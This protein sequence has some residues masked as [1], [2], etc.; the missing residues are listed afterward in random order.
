MIGVRTDFRDG[1]VHGL[2]IM[3][4]GICT[5]IV[6]LPSTSSSIGDIA[7]QVVRAVAGRPLT[8]LA[9]RGRMHLDSQGSLPCQRQQT[10]GNRPSGNCSFGGASALIPNALIAGFLQRPTRDHDSAVASR[11]WGTAEIA[12]HTRDWK[13]AAY[14]GLSTLRNP[15]CPTSPSEIEHRSSP[16]RPIRASRWRWPIIR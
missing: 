10:I 13:R 4:A 12:R 6:K 1:E 2:N 5:S 8:R 11:D 16:P 15:P 14:R 7:E 9:K 3:T